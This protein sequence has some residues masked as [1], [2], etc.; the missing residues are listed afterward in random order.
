VSADLGRAASVGG[1][2]VPQSW[3]TASPAIR[4]VST[5][6][7]T[8]GLDG[9]PGA[10]AAGPAGSFGGMPPVASVVNAPRNGAAG[11]RS[12]SRLKVIPQI[13]TESG[14]DKSAPGRWV[15]APAGDATV[16][17]RDE[18]NGLRRATAELA[19]ERDVLMRSAALLIKEALAR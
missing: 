7:P 19:K 13:G 10:G 17:E 9:L 18:L 2:S 15:D 3:G 12:E 1:L 6:L 16:S 14:D 11:A 8:G 4:L 5:A